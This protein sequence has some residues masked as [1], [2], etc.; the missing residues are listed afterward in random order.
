MTKFIRDEPLMLDV[1]DEICKT[2]GS[3]YGDVMDYV[4]DKE[5]AMYHDR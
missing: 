5:G 2:R 1:V 3:N 4:T